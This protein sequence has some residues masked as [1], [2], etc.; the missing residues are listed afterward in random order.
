MSSLT[1]FDPL[2]IIGWIDLQ[3][4]QCKICFALV[5]SRHVQK[6]PFDINLLICTLVTRTIFDLNVLIQWGFQGCPKSFYYTKEN[7]KKYKGKLA[8]C[9]FNF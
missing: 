6:T 9:I 4:M 8:V 7:T 5:F 3:D 1:T 2:L